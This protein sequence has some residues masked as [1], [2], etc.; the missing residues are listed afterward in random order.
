ML[1]TSEQ[2][3]ADSRKLCVLRDCADFRMQCNESEGPAKL[4]PKEIRRLR[5][6][7]SP[8]SRLHPNLL[9]GQRGWLD[10]ESSSQFASSNSRSSSSESTNSPRAACAMDSRSM[11]FSSADTLKVSFASDE[12]TVT[13][14]PSGS[15]S[16][17]TTTRPSRTVPVMIR[18]AR[19]YRVTPRATRI[20]YGSTASPFDQAL[21]GG[22]TLMAKCRCGVSGGALPVVPT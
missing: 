11:R 8:P 20:G 4:L 13:R 3:P 12:R 10:R 2:N 22:N 5:S 6:M 1:S 15:G 21:F 17:S 9:C 7:V 18:I 19:F 16:P 14:R